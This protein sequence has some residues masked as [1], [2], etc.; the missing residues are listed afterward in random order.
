MRGATKARGAGNEGDGCK[1]RRISNTHEAD[2]DDAPTLAARSHEG[3]LLRGEWCRLR[4]TV[5]SHYDKLKTKLSN[6]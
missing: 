5:S 4:F 2:T 1:N 3:R 6:K